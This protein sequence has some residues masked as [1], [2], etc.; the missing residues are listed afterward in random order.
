[1]EPVTTAP[2]PEPFTAPHAV[3]RRAL[4]IGG[5]AALAAGTAAVVL[6]RPRLSP[7]LWTFESPFP[8]NQGP[9]VTQGVVLAAGPETYALDPRSGKVRWR[10]GT[11]VEALPVARDGRWFLYDGSSLN[12]LDAATGRPLWSEPVDTSGHAPMPV[13]LNDVVCMPGSRAGGSYALRAFGATTGRRRWVHKLDGW[14]QGL[15]AAG[16]TFCMAI[17]DKLYAVD[18]ATGNLRWQQAAGGPIASAPIV[19]GGLILVGFYDHDVRAFDAATGQPR[20]QAAIGGENAGI[21][22]PGAVA[23]PPSPAVVG[24]TVFAGTPNALHA[25]NASDGHT[26]WRIEI[27]SV[28]P[29][30]E[31]RIVVAGQIAILNSDAG[32]IGLDMAGGK[33]LWRHP[34]TAPYERPVLMNGVV[35]LADTDKVL[36]LDPA[37]GDVRVRIVD[38]ALPAGAIRHPFTPSYLIGAGG[39]LCCNVNAKAVYALR[40]SELNSARSPQ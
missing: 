28:W 39:V 2:V 3:S 17:A 30:N 23:L 36:G 11:Q 21:G 24:G 14:P 15:A 18:A 35:Y 26:R 6:T 38:P 25:L 31:I 22:R 10:G 7:V 32:L 1:M 19:S 4:V 33:P 8:L 40:P 13:V 37:T 29:A 20:W 9:H 27:R 5:A 12:A 16:G 34:A